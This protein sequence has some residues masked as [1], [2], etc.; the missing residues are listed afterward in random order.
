MA[1]Q[2]T[3]STKLITLNFKFLYR[4]ISTNNFLK[5]I[6]LV[7][8]EKY[9]F[10]KR[11]TEKLAYLFWACP[12][13]QYFWT[14]FK[15]WL[16][17]CQ[18]IAKETSLEPDRALG[19]RP[20]S[21]KHK[22]QINFCCLSAKYYIWLCRQKKMFSKTKWFLT[23]FKT[24]LWNGKK[25]TTIILKK[26]GASVASFVISWQLDPSPLKMKIKMKGKETRRRYTMHIFCNLQ[27]RIYISDRSKLVWSCC[28]RIT[29]SASNLIMLYCKQCKY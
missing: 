1:F 8:S 17:S 26:V 29:S 11:E 14:N 10:C 15:V 21:A 5:K 9:T 13:T 25:T 28:A 6:G 3:K 19:L 23:V 18:V 4:R 20:D 22:L 24:Y 27:F 7:D 2:C 12:K 16:Q